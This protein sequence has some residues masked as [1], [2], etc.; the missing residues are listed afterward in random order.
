MNGIYLYLNT[1][2]R[3]TPAD[4]RK[5]VIQ[6]SF[7]NSDSTL[8]AE[9]PVDSA[10]AAESVLEV[11]FRPD[12]VEAVR[13]VVGLSNREGSAGEDFGLHF[14]GWWGGGVR[15]CWYGGWRT[16]KEGGEVGYIV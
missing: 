4:C 14:C 16:S 6:V 8:A 12:A 2:L 3:T 1:S 7:V 13:V 11:D 5:P 15:M 10:D 9:F